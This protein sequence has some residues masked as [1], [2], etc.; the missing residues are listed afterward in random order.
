[1]EISNC[2]IQLVKL[3]S[4]CRQLTHQLGDSGEVHLKS[5]YIVVKQPRLCLLKFSSQIGIA[6]SHNVRVANGEA[7]MSLF[8]FKNP[9][10]SS[11]TIQH[12]KRQ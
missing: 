6:V 11:Y 4:L 1:M 2:K 8:N 9:K 12:N 10:I 3:E 5:E 7:M